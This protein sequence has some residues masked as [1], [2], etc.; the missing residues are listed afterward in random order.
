MFR[1]NSI[2]TIAILLSIQ[3]VKG[4]ET[5]TSTGVFNAYLHTQGGFF[6]RDSSIGASN[7]PQYDHQLFGGETRLEA[8]YSNWGF[9]IGVRYDFFQNSTN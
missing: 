9:D 3:S 1:F 5:V 2:L 8:I 7:T 6:V 4:Q